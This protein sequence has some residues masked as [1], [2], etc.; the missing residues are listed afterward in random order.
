MDHVKR[1]KGGDFME[2]RRHNLSEYIGRVKSSI[3][4]KIPIKPKTF[5]DLIAVAEREGVLSLTATVRSYTD[6][7]GYSEASWGGGVIVVGRGLETNFESVT[8][9]GKKIL[10]REYYGY[11]KTESRSPTEN[12]A[13][14]R[15]LVTAER[16]LQ[17]VQERLPGVVTELVGPGGIV[18]EDERAELARV[19][20]DDMT[21]F[22]P[23]PNYISPLFKDL[24]E[25]RMVLL[26]RKSG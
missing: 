8:P 9:A 7:V 11:V 12:A 18:G 24:N 10:H 21:S 6:S 23:V 1:D 5:E 4:R 22:K 26:E 17:Q 19:T 15:T 2:K 3:E 25:I 16:R 13:M 14:H 20:T